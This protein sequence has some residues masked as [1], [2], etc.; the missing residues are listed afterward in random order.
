MNDDD[1][2]PETRALIEANT[3]PWNSFWYWRD[4]PVGERG[5]AA[6]ILRHAGIKVAGLVSRNQDPPD[7]EGMLDRQWSAVEITELVH[8]PTLK[9]SIKA[10]K[11]RAA[12]R[13]PEK[14]EAY[15]EWSSR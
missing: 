12:G 6:E 4:K 14:T 15:F 9:R 5:V 8:G 11:E 10:Q 1:N 7:C 13:E 3:R 2:Q